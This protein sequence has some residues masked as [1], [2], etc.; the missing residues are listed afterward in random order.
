MSRR[1]IL[2][3]ILLYEQ[4]IRLTI[5]KINLH[6]NIQF[7]NTQQHTYQSFLVTS[8]FVVHVHLKFTQHANDANGIKAGSNSNMT[9]K[10]AAECSKAAYLGVK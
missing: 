1:P 3:A 10:H 8:W 5:S 6:P 2:L 4:F 7:L 9:D